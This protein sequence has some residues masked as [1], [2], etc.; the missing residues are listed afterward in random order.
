MS[1]EKKEEKTLEEQIKELRK[2]V[3]ALIELETAKAKLELQRTQMQRREEEGSVQ[4]QQTI[5]KEELKEELKQHPIG[6]LVIYAIKKD[7]IPRGTREE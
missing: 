4:E 1:E 3:E 2:T 5:D 7:L 6:E